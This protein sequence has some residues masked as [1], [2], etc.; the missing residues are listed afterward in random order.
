MDSGEGEGGGG[1]RERQR[2]RDRGVPSPSLPPA[3]HIPTLTD[4]RAQG[5]A[6]RR[7]GHD[8]VG[9]AG[10]D[11]QRGREREKGGVCRVAE[12]GG[13]MREEARAE[14]GEGIT[15]TRDG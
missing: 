12:A 10:V 4:G 11:H 3:L 1:V 7:A 15:H 13:A 6:H 14:G 2:E 9:A 8:P 5:A